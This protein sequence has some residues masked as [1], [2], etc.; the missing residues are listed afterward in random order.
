M[1]TVAY[2]HTLQRAW[3]HYNIAELEAEANK[4]RPF[5]NAKHSNEDKIGHLTGF[6]KSK[7][8]RLG[9]YEDSVGLSRGMISAFTKWLLAGKLGNC[10]NGLL[11][12]YT[13]RIN[14]NPMRRRAKK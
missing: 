14:N 11:K 2:C 4:P 1:T 6:M 12:Y 3:D 8:L 13:D 5:S 9:E 10:D 7:G